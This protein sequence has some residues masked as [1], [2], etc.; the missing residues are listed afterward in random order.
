[1][2][3]KGLI[4]GCQ[5]LIEAVVLRN[6]AR[7]LAFSSITFV[8]KQRSMH[9]QYFTKATMGRLAYYSVLLDFA[10]QKKKKN[11]LCQS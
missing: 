11:L 1:M 4:A 6:L 7:T 10:R 9:T 3:H 5:A 8:Q 2:R